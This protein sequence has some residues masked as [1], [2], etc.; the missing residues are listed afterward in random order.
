MGFTNA[1][2]QARYRNKLKA[3]A[4]ASLEETVTRK[5]QEILDEWV[6]QDDDPERR[7][8]AAL[9]PR[10]GEA[11]ESW[12]GQVLVADLEHEFRRYLEEARRQKLRERA[13]T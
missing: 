9:P 2:R 12:I 1:E 5:R 13:V 8:F 4:R 10:T 3:T 7:D 6:S 11:F